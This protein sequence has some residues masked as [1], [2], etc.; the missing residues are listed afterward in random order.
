ML[1]LDF[2]S[3]VVVE[4]PAITNVDRIVYSGT[5]PSLQAFTLCHWINIVYV[6]SITT[7]F[8]YANSERDNALLIILLKNKAMRIYLN[9]V[10]LLVKSC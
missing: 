8:S 2:S 9:N 7:T 4:F 3:N 1:I 6:A 10:A 5:L